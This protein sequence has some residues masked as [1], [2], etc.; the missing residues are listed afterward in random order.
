MVGGDQRRRDNLGDDTPRRAPG[1]GGWRW[2]YW[3]PS[4]GEGAGGADVRELRKPSPNRGAA[5]TRSA[6][7]KGGRGW[8]SGSTAC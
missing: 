1:V 3:G 8:P 2:T 6:P 7:T 5:S 4:G